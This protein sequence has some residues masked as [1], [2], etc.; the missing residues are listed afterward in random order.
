MDKKI[1]IDNSNCLNEKKSKVAD[2]KNSLKNK[3]VKAKYI[4]YQ[5]RKSINEYFYKTQMRQLA[6]MKDKEREVKNLKEF[7]SSLIKRFEIAQIEGSHALKELSEVIKFKNNR[8]L[9]LNSKNSLYSSRKLVDS[10][11]GNIK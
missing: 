4:D 2:I 5:K 10:S 8:N 9:S 3:D 1:I 6:I 7:E 11:I